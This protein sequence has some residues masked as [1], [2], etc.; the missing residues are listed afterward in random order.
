MTQ[1]DFFFGV[2]TKREFDQANQD[3]FLVPALGATM[4]LVG[5]YVVPALLRRLKEQRA[6]QKIK[7]Q[8]FLDQR[9]IIVSELHRLEGI[10]DLYTDFLAG[11]SKW[12]EKYEN[13]ALRM[14][15]F[16]EIRAGLLLDVRKTLDRD[17]TLYNRRKLLKG[18]RDVW[19]TIPLFGILK[20]CGTRSEMKDS[21]PV[22]DAQNILEAF[23]V[24]CEPS[25]KFGG[26]DWEAVYHKIVVP[27]LGGL[28]V[29]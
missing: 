29:A 13:S 21:M 25:L 7:E 11:G 9:K 18:L 3:H 17:L 16:N 22:I 12:A 4:A 27:L 23:I 8:E 2:L 6:N 10:G 19:G 24:L 15:S 14:A 26:P 20:N 28:P 1:I 5:Y